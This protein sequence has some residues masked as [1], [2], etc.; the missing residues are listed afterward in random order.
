MMLRPSSEDTDF[1]CT[2]CGCGTDK[3]GIPWRSQEEADGCC[4]IIETDEYKAEIRNRLRTDKRRQRRR[5][6][7]LRRE[8][9]N[10]NYHGRN[11]FRKEERDYE[12]R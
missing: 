7:R 2:Y 1:R 9:K 12:E 4:K 10:Q 6:E 8:K 11:K 3:K 5:K